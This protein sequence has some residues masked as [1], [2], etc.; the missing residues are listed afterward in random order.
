MSLNNAHDWKVNVVVVNKYQTSQLSS[1]I[2]FNIHKEFWISNIIVDKSWDFWYLFETIH[3]WWPYTKLCSC[4]RQLP[5][6]ENLVIGSFRSKNDKK[7]IVSFHSNLKIEKPFSLF[8]AMEVISL[9]NQICFQQ[10]F[11]SCLNF[12]HFEKSGV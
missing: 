2:I 7:K 11:S 5:F 1:T 12:K 6:C 3:P 8:V 9:V 4:K 10:F